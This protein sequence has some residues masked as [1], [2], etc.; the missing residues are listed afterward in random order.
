MSQVK[1]DC[2]FQVKD[3]TDIVVPRESYQR[4]PYYRC[5][6]KEPVRLSQSRECDGEECIFRKIIAKL[7]GVLCAVPPQQ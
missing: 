5:V 1:V 7:S 4:V 6:L 2:N 3:E